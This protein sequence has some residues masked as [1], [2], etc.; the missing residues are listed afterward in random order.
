MFVD[1]EALWDLV[2]R[3]REKIAQ[4]R[5]QYLSSRADIAYG[6]GLNECAEE[7]SDLILALEDQIAAGT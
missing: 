6:Q 1:E 7:L 5:G 4:P 3:W 2:E